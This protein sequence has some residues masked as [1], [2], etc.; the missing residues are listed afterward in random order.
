MNV[1]SLPLTS[2]SYGG[3]RSEIGLEDER[4]LLGAIRLGDRAAA[5]RMVGRTYEGVYAALVRLCGGDTDLAADLTQDSYQKA[6][7]SIDGFD[8]RSKLSTWLYRIAYTTFLNHIRRPRLMQ[9]L[10]ETSDI[11]DQ[12]AR[13]AE[14]TLATREEGSRLREAVLELP[15]ELR[16]TVTAHFWAD[17]TVREIAE[18]ERVTSVAIRKRLARAFRF[19]QSLLLEEPS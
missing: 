18:I 19:L 9:S 14:E 16:F 15:E 1:S 5:E 8:G 13:G 10:T 2:T 17:L 12:D 11:P 4:E 6:W 3:R 7:S